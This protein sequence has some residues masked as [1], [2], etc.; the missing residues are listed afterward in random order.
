MHEFA[1]VPLLSIDD[2]GMRNLPA[3]PFSVGLSCESG[4]EGGH[5]VSARPYL[6]PR[7]WGALRI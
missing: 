7:R 3:T 1:S 6:A 4:S 2:L 5:P